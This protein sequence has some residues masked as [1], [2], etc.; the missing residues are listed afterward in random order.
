[1]SYVKELGSCPAC[2][3]EVVH[4]ET[5]HTG[6]CELC[7]KEYESWYHCSAG[8]SICDICYGRFAFEKLKPYFC[9]ASKNPWEIFHTLLDSPDFGMQGCIHYAAVPLC[10]L[11]A[12]GNILGIPEDNHTNE[13]ILKLFAK[14]IDQIPV[15]NCRKCS[16]CGIVQVC[17]ITFGIVLP[18]LDQKF[19]NKFLIRRFKAEMAECMAAIPK[20]D[21]PCCKEAA[22]A[23][24]AQLVAFLNRYL[25][26]NLAFPEKPVCKYA[27][28]NPAC[29]GAD[30]RYYPK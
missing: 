8:H 13:K 25:D 28:V 10:V 27:K 19:E 5:P 4:E 18:F 7:G 3:G 14:E 26:V 22:Y 20:S 23:C 29:R 12:L 16:E 6:V 15:S 30:C 24:L 21:N 9:I 17:C 1:M 2:R 11:L